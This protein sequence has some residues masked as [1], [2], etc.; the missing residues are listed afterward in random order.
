MLTH[1]SGCIASFIRMANFFQLNALSDNTW[2]SIQLMSWTLAEPGVILICACAPALWPL[3]RRAGGMSATK[4][5]SKYGK[6]GASGT[7]GSNSR[8]QAAVWNNR[9]VTPTS[10]SDDGIPLKDVQESS[11][12]FQEYRSAFRQSSIY[13]GVQVTKAYTVTHHSWS[14][15]QK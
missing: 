13:G 12:N 9:S 2:A 15:Q 5:Q 14:P 7:N 10:G 1:F 3:I 4:N 8:A 6:S 11:D